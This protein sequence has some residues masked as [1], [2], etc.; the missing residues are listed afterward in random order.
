MT[1]QTGDRYTHITSGQ[2]YTILGWVKVKV[3][4]QWWDC[5]EY[6]NVNPE[7]PGKYARNVSDFNVHFLREIPVIQGEYQ[8][9]N[10]GG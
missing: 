1:I 8:G 6:E 4:G 2:V 9:D 5:V 7:K 10:H 3:N